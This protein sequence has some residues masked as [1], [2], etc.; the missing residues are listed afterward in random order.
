MSCKPEQRIYVGVAVAAQFRE[1]AEREDRKVA[2]IARRALEAY[3][4]EQ[5]EP[6]T[7]ADDRGTGQRQAVTPAA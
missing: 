6:D 1:Q 7:L 2:A 4:R 5:G 3:R